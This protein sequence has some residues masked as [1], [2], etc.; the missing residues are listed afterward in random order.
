MPPNMMVSEEGPLTFIV[1]KAK[2]ILPTLEFPAY[3]WTFVETIFSAIMILMRIV[4]TLL[5]TS[6]GTLVDKV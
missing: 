2:N 3:W 5:A 4:L 6:E 1:I